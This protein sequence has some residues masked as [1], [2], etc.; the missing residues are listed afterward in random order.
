MRPPYQPPREEEWITC[1]N[2]ATPMLPLRDYDIHKSESPGVGMELWEFLL[3]G[4][5]ALLFNYVYDFFTLKGRVAKLGEL[6]A[7]V[8]PQFPNSQVCPRC[9]EIKKRP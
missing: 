3:F 4:F 7:Q 9:L 2:C 5:W 1:S 8:L 6:K